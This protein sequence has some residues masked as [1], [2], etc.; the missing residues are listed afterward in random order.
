V[1]VRLLELFESYRVIRALLDNLP[2]GP[3]V[4]RM[5]RRIPA[6][7]TVSRVEAPRGEL[8]YFIQSHGTDKPE[9]IK[10]RTPTLCNMASAVHLAVGRYLADVPML[11]AGVDPC[12]SCND[13]AVILRGSDVGN[14][15]TWAR[16]REHGI[17]FYR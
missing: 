11:L 1:L 10:V 13:R 8:L 9:R 16:L 7:E 3:L 4:A 12:F 2:E 5:P 6:G 15:W 14:T 17:E